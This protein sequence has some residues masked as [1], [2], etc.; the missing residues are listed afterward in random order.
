MWKRMAYNP[1][2]PFR[3][4]PK[5]KCFFSLHIPL[6]FAR[7]GAWTGLGRSRLSRQLIEVHNFLQT[8]QPRVKQRKYKQRK[9]KKRKC[10][11]NSAKSQTKEIQRQLTRVEQRKDRDNSAK[12]WTKEGA[13]L[14]S[15]FQVLWQPGDQCQRPILKTPLHCF[16]QVR[17]FLF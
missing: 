2:P 15:F 9:Y 4:C 10:S 16:D 1:P 11:D 12:S 3:K 13:L 5:R 17:V 8:T 6:E 14:V 7:C